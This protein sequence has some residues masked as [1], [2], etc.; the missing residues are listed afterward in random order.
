MPKYEGTWGCPLG[1]RE[2]LECGPQD[3]NQLPWGSIPKSFLGVVGALAGIPLLL[4]H[5]PSIPP[6]VGRILESQMPQ[7]P[8][9]QFPHLIWTAESPETP[10]AILWEHAPFLGGGRG[11]PVFPSTPDRPLKNLSLMGPLPRS[12][13]PPRVP[14]KMSSPPA[15]YAG[16]HSGLQVF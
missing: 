7:F 1:H 10:Q 8:G 2:P 13:L 6:S 3:K 12:P 9:S 15:S 14:W 4:L 5:C 16:G 11:V